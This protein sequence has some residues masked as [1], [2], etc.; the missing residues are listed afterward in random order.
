[1]RN[2]AKPNLYFGFVIMIMESYWQY[3]EWDEI[4]GYNWSVL[5]PIAKCHFHNIGFFTARSFVQF[6]NDTSFPI[7]GFAQKLYISFY[8]AWGFRNF[9]EKKTWD[10]IDMVCSNQYLFRETFLQL[11]TKWKG[12]IWKEKFRTYRWLECMRICFKNYSYI[13]N[14]SIL[15]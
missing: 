11:E 1:M 13:P 12:V 3:T 5:F 9:S 7:S 2:C 8:G 15:S 10:I 6:E 4:W 14:G